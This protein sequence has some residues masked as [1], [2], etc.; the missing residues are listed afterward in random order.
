MGDGGGD[1]GEG[2]LLLHGA[3]FPSGSRHAVDDAGGL[4]LTEGGGA[5]LAHG[6]KPLGSVV[7]HA[8]ED[9]ACG[10]GSDVGRHGVE[11]NVDRGAAAVNLGSHATGDLDGVAFPVDGHVKVPGRNVDGVFLHPVP[12]GPFLYVEDALRIQTLGEELGK[13]SWNVLGNDNAR[14]GWTQCF[15][16]GSEGLGSPGG[17]ADGDEL[18]LSPVTAGGRDAHRRHRSCRSYRRCRGRRRRWLDGGHALFLPCGSRHNASRT[19]ACSMGARCEAARPRV[20]SLRSTV[21]DLFDMGGQS[22]VERS[23]HLRIHGLFDVP[24]KTQLCEMGLVHEPVGYDGD[25]IMLRQQHQKPLTIDLYRGHRIVE[26]D[27]IRMEEGHLL[28]CIHRIGGLFHKTAGRKI[29]LQPVCQI[30][31]ER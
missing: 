16:D 30:I 15:E 27:D 25:V 11:E 2:E 8:R 14:K 7:P 31:P 21:H 23:A 24:C 3:H 5:F 9:D 6:Q 22:P 18:D 12:I 4:V 26:N 28:Q 29:L 1:G 20:S 17:G 13:E 10:G 19:Q